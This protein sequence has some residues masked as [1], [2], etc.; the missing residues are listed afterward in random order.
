MTLLAK[1]ALLS[2]ARPRSPIFTEPV[3]PVMKMLS[4]LR[5]RW[6]MGGCGCA[7]SGAPWG[8]V[9]SSSGAASASSPWSASSTW[10][11]KFRSFFLRLNSVSHCHGGRKLLRAPRC[12]TSCCSTITLTAERWVLSWKYSEI[13]FFCGDSTVG[14]L[15]WRRV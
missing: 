14:L 10:K 13:L 9:G 12:D 1:E 11:G 2:V 15:L 5:S 3:G 8:S 6:M 4:H 7:G